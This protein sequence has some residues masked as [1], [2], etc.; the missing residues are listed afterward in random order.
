VRRWEAGQSEPDESDL[1]RFAD[2]CHL[3]LLQREFLLRLFTRNSL[4]ATG[5]PP[6]FRSEAAN[7][8]SIQRPAYVV[9]E[10]FYIRAW[11]SFFS[12]FAGPF[13][14]RLQEGINAVEL[15]LQI[16]SL[17]D[18]RLDSERSRSIARLTWMWT[19]HLARHPAYADLM[20]RLLEIPAFAT[21]WLQIPREAV[22]SQ[23][24]PLVMPMVQRK[25]PGSFFTVYTGQLVFPPL[26]H[27][28]VYEP[29]DEQAAALLQSQTAGA[30][31]SVSFA[32]R[33]HWSD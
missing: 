29:R 10:L 32:G 6:N 9:D 4:S 26:Y 25:P 18:P 33:L 27:V 31:P 12:N 7:V 23:E 22:E 1:L 20:K 8:L 16:G 11:N 30:S 28:F 17:D 24:P 19:A 2:V 13:A 21:H 14:G 5:A 15:G 3:S